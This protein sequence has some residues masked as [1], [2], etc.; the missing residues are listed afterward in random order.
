M[1]ITPELIM[2]VRYEVQDVTPG[3]YVIDNETIAYFLEKHH[4]N[5]TRASMDVARAM[6]FRLSQDSSTEIVDIFTIRNGAS[7]T[8]FKE[9]LQ[10]YLKN[11][12]LN[13][14]NSNL[15]GWVGGV[16][17]SEMLAN[18]ADLDNNHVQSP[19]KD[20]D[21]RD[22]LGNGSLTFPLF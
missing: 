15:K 20:R 11:P 8:A 13:P 12:Y 16:S 18:D 22:I 9:A 10:L 19:S 1:A 2:Q 21:I 4:G 3:L 6:L 17:K 14:L 7:A 5:V